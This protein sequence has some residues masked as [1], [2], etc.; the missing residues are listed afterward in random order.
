MGV[1]I[2]DKTKSRFFLS[3]LQQKGVEVDWFMDL[4]DNIPADNP[5]HE[6]LTLA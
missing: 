2:D 4:L 5:L 6:E 1:S 3:A